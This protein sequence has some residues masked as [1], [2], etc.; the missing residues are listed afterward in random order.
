K[1][2]VEVANE[3]KDSVSNCRKRWRNI[4]GAFLRSMKQLP[5]GTGANE[6]NYLNERLEF[7]LRYVKNKAGD[8]NL[9]T[10]IA[11]NESSDEGNSDPEDHT[12]DEEETMESEADQRGQDPAIHGYA[13]S[14]PDMTDQGSTQDSGKLTNS[15][16]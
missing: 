10:V 15:L 5:S 8:G 6:K 9:K 7:L 12:D 13:S 1:A 14:P 4:R 16:L 2:W 11:C 3:I